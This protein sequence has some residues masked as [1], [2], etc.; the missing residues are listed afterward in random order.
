VTGPA[1]PGEPFELIYVGIAPARSSS[2][3]SLRSRVLRQHLGGNIGSSTFR[4]SLAA[5]LSEEE[6]WCTRRSA[7]RA[8]LTPEDNLAL[9]AWQAK[10]LRLT[11]VG[12]GAPWEIESEVIGLMQPPL[13]LAG[14][15]SHPLHRLLTE[16]RA[17]LRRGCP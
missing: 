14:N 6:G 12:C 2:S 10:N 7:T 16:R 15:R 17:A 5:L 4:Q 9:S 3:A 1:H 11:W 13:N 8:L